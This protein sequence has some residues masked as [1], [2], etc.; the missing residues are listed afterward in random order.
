MKII[1]AFATALLLYL[2]HPGNGFFLLSFIAFIPLIYSLQDSDKGEMFFYPFLTGVLYFLLI[3]DWIRVLHLYSNSWIIFFGV[4]LIAALFQSLFWG[5]AGYLYAIFESKHINNIFILPAIFTV[6]EWV[7]SLGI[8]GNTIGSLAYHQAAN[9]YFVSIA[10]II[11]AAGL[12]F[13]VLLF[14]QLVFEIISALMNKK[15]GKASSYASL[16]LFLLAAVMIIAQYNI[17]RVDKLLLSTEKKSIAVFQPSIIQEKK[18][19]P[20]HYPELKRFYLANLA[21]FDQRVDLIILPETIVAE[22]LLSNKSFMWNLNLNIAEDIIFG[23]P[24]NRPG[25]GYYNSMVYLN[26]VSGMTELYNKVKI[27]PFGE[28]LPWRE[29]FTAIVGKKIINNYFGSEYIAGKEIKIVADIFAPAICF[30]SFMADVIRAGVNKGGEMI[31]V[32]T[33]DAWFKQTSMLREHQAAG[34]LRAVENNRFVVQA[35]NTGISFVA[36]P[37][38][39]VIK[40]LSIDQKGWLVEQV[41]LLGSK[42]PYTLYGEAFVYLLIIILIF[43]LYLET[44]VKKYARR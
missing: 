34:R 36:A 11:G 33:N 35:A 16:L 37:D 32:L 9:Q 26:K 19:D 7:R 39:R 42:T 28:Y 43:N 10:A 13:F 6:I 31:L 8:F 40:E 29:F 44:L 14:N 12:V 22:F 41:P 18:I 24:V 27:V 4:S 3:T 38:G 30:E 2:S 15:P 5:A 21:A 1:F 17:N 23:T 20:R 25:R